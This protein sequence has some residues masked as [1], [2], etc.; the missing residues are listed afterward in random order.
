MKQA[1]FRSKHQKCFRVPVELKGLVELK[2]SRHGGLISP[3]SAMHSVLYTKS[4]D[5]RV[6]EIEFPFG[7]MVLYISTCMYTHSVTGCEVK[8][9]CHCRVTHTR[10]YES[11]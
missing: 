11:D 1:C 7:S 9:V 3:E 4:Q 8:I 6:V 2:F 5:K 10:F